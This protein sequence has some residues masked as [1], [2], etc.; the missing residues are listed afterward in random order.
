MHIVS[1]TVFFNV[2]HCYTT[3]RGPPIGS[4]ARHN[5][6]LNPEITS[7]SGGCTLPHKQW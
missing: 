2:C 7:G 4:T 5:W 3:S 6:Q 1:S